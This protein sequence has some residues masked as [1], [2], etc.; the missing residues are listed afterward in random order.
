MPRSSVTCRMMVAAAGAARV[1]LKN[2]NARASSLA[3]APQES[4]RQVKQRSWSC[5]AGVGVQR[6]SLLCLQC[7]Q[8]HHASRPLLPA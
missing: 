5:V 1:A 2:P 7:L 4:L 3:P 6:V 8:R